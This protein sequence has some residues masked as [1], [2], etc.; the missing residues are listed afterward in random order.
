MAFNYVLRGANSRSQPSYSH[1]S[2]GRDAS[3][4]GASI[5]PYASSST[6]ASQMAQLGAATVHT[7]SMKSYV[8]DEEFHEAATDI[9]L[10][11][12]RLQNMQLLNMGLTTIALVLILSLH[13]K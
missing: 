7:P 4:F 5:H 8:D 11:L 3:R 10:E 12:R 6:F 13:S 1:S 9:E 2:F